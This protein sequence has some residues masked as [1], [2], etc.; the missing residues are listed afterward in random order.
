MRLGRPCSCTTWWRC[1]PSSPG[2]SASRN[3]QP[4][5]REGY[6]GDTISAHPPEDSKFGASYGGEPLRSPVDGDSGR[7]S[8]TRSGTSSGSWQERGRTPRRIS[9]RSSD[10]VLIC[11]RHFTL[12][13]I[14]TRAVFA[15]QGGSVAVISH[16]GAA[17]LSH[18]TVFCILLCFAPVF[19][20][21]RAR[22][23]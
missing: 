23:Y 18:E 22:L 4:L 8:W 16:R 20:L 11:W 2:K 13:R 7:T 6:V 3:S 15:V 12:T 14:S 17:D 1:L 19:L 10:G 21:S 9:R 5:N